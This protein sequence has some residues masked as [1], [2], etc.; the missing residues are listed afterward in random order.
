MVI[1]ELIFTSTFLFLKL[2]REGVDPLPTVR[3]IL[4]SVLIFVPMRHTDAPTS[5]MKGH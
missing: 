4:V 5:S 2:I 1:E 3:S